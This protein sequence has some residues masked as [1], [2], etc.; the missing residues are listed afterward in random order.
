VI[1]ILNYR[2]GLLQ[3]SL[4]ADENAI[5]DSSMDLPILPSNLS[6]SERVRI[7]IDT[8]RKNRDYQSRPGTPMNVEISDPSLNGNRPVSQ[9]PESGSQNAP[10]MSLFP[11]SVAPGVGSSLN[12][13]SKNLANVPQGYRPLKPLTRPNKKA[14]NTK[15]EIDLK[16]SN[17]IQNVL[18]HTSNKK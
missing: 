13:T 5:L 9:M 3:P 15:T 17:M 6:A 14:S 16:V 4:Y 12:N 10:K 11:T 18:N 7:I 1:I 8:L 2:A